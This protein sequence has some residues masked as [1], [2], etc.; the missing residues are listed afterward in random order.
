MRIEAL[1]AVEV[2]ATVGLTSMAIGAW[3]VAMAH[4]ASWFLAG[5]RPGSHPSPVTVQLVIIEGWLA[6]ATTVALVGATRVVRSLRAV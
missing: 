2:A 1:L 5:T 4:G 6:A 3:W